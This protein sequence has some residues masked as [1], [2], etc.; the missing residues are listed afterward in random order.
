[1]RLSKNPIPTKK[2]YYIVGFF[3]CS[4]LTDNGITIQKK[5]FILLIT[6]IFIYYLFLYFTIIFSILLLLTR[7]HKLTSTTPKNPVN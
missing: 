1:M 2:A 6:N 3:L 7:L 4:P 5:K